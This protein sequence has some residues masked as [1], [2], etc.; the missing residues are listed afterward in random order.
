MTVLD[1][2][3][4]GMV[5]TYF[6]RGN[7]QHHASP[8]LRKLF[9]DAELCLCSVNILCH[10][11]EIKTPSSAGSMWTLYFWKMGRQSSLP[12][13]RNYSLFHLLYIYAFVQYQH[14]M[15]ENFSWSKITYLKRKITFHC[16]TTAQLP[17]NMNGLGFFYDI[18][19]K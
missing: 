7:I 11:T 16:K 14:K 9:R 17:K 8:V 12:E 13:H 15:H 6:L 1:R 2:Q 3:D 5:L 4:Q 10:L 19:I 18:I